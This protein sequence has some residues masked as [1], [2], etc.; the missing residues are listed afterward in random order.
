MVHVE[1]VAMAHIFLLEY[2]GAKGRYICSSDRISLNG[3]SE[4]LSAR[5]PDLQIP[6]KEWVRISCIIICFWFVKKVH[7]ILLAG[8]FP[9]IS[10]AWHPS[11]VQV[12]EGHYRLQTMRPLVGKAPGLWIQIRAWSWGHVWWS[13]TILQGEGVYLE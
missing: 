12:L 1:D 4:F 10:P 13:Y 6:T 8:L 9:C 7:S 11:C 5:Y 3:M 2:P